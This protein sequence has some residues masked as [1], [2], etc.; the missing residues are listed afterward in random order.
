MISVLYVDDEPHLSEIATAFLEIDGGIR[1][2]TAPDAAAA[3]DLIARGTYDAIVSD[4]QMPGMDGIA[5]LKELRARENFIPFIL[6]TGKSR[7]DVAIEALNSGAD[8]YLQKSAD[9]ST[10]FVELRNLIQQSHRRR[11][12]EIAHQESEHRFRSIVEDQNEMIARFLPDGRITYANP[13]FCAFF[14]IEPRSTE[15]NRMNALPLPEERRLVQEHLHSLSPEIPVR[16]ITHRIQLAD[17]RIRWIRSSDRAF[18][19]PDGN[20]CA[21]QAVARDITEI[22]TISDSMAFGERVLR[23]IAGSNDILTGEDSIKMISDAIGQITGTLTVGRAHLW[24]E[25]DVGE[26]QPSAAALITWNQKEGG[27]EIQ[28]FQPKMAVAHSYPL[29][30]QQI[31]QGGESVEGAIDTLPVDE[32]AWL[33][34]YGHASILLVPI[35][36]KGTFWGFFGIESACPGRRWAPEEYRILNNVSE[37]IGRVVIWFQTNQILIENQEKFKAIAERAQDAIIIA[38]GQDRVHYWNPAAERMFGF[39]FQEIGCRRLQECIQNGEG[40]VERFRKQRKEL[41]TTGTSPLTACAHRMEGRRNGGDTFPVEVTISGIQK[42]EEWMALVIARDISEQKRMETLLRQSEE[43]YRTIFDTTLDGM[44]VLDAE[45]L[46]IVFANGAA[47]K[48]MGCDPVDNFEEVSLFDFIPEERW[49][50]LARIIRDDLFGENPQ[51]VHELPVIRRDG[52]ERWVRVVGKKALFR[53]K[54]AGIVSC[55]DITDQKHLEMRLRRRAEMEVMVSSISTRLL[56]LKSEQ[57]EEGFTAALGSICGVIGADAAHLF[58]LDTEQRGVEVVYEWC[59]EG[60]PPAREVAVCLM[61]GD[62]PWWMEQL[63]TSRPF[64]ISRTAD[65]PPQAAAEREILEHFNVRSTF[66][67]PITRNDRPYGFLLFHSILGEREWDEDEIAI[68]HILADTFAEIYL[69]GRA[70]KRLQE[71]VTRFRSF[72]EGTK[73]VSMRLVMQPDGPPNV[74]YLSPSWE[75]FIGYSREEVFRDPFFGLKVIHPEDRERFMDMQRHPEQHVNRPLQYRYRHRDGHYIW[76]EEYVIPEYDS[77]GTLVAVETVIHSID[78][79]K[80]TEETLRQM[81]SK[82]SLLGSITRHDILNQ[83]TVIQGYQDILVDSIADPAL[84]P[85]FN[86]QQAAI[87]RII[88]HIAFMKSYQE[89]G[90][91]LPE[92]QT[93]SEVAKRA[94]ALANLNGTDLTVDADGYSV[95]ADPMLEKV[96]FNFYDNALRHGGDVKHIRVACEPQ[97]NCLRVI[98]E[99]DGA[100]I[101]DADKEKIFRR[102]VGRNTGLGLFLVREVLLITGFSIKENGAEGEGARFEI[103]VPAGMY[104]RN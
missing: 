92:W 63:Q 98:V 50:A 96:F 47:L 38:D 91:R 53:G 37:T 43:A 73:D 17:G 22:R 2:T 101:P 31:F 13:A 56:N 18:F 44:F 86:Q 46:R 27:S 67:Q 42:D 52:M 103:E 68:F 69:R 40:D 84:Q 58:W 24:K 19:D 30:W 4:Y 41:M 5:F 34:E 11:T 23:I 26:H 76:A 15:E 70:E 3:L 90:A 36:I 94:G 88:G 78:H 93:L 21:Y 29:R 8:Y 7:E 85:F 1:V 59:L 9:T 64:R 77:K 95:Y 71:S 49:D 55:I 20:I 81:N 83:L 12:A 72:V 57:M 60:L 33:A 54:T 97:E 10:Q 74:D 14:G 102:G 80:Q 45:T 75:E 35:M 32:A 65:L 25:M 82:L 51:H 104:R 87:D 48:I 61:T 39:S 28:T 6:F 79:I 16:E 89:L 99:D 66:C 100:G 62:H